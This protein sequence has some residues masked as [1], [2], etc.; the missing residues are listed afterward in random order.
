MSTA[1]PSENAGGPASTAI[2]NVAARNRTAAQM[3]ERWLADSFGD[4][5]EEWPRMQRELVS[6]PVSFDRGAEDFPAGQR[7]AGAVVSSPTGA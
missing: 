7:R 5:P 6:D 4:D 3:L 1:L 2:G